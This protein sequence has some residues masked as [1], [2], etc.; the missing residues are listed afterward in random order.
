VR[1]IVHLAVPYFASWAGITVLDGGRLRSVDSAGVDEFAEGQRPRKVA[2][3]EPAAASAFRRAS[4]TAQR[5]LG[6]VGPDVVAAFAVPPGP[7]EGLATAGASLLT[8]P[9]PMAGAAAV[10]ALATIDEPDADEL[11]GFA[12]RAARALAAASAYEERGVLARTLRASL[13]PAPLPE[14]AGLE[15]AGAYRPAQESTEIGGDFYDVTPRPDGT[16]AISIGDV[17]GKGVE[18]AVLTGQVRQSLRTASLVTDDPAAA[19]H[20]LNDTLLR[21]D[22]STFATTAFGILDVRSDGARLRLASG[23]HPPPLLLR[24]DGRVEVVGVRGT[25]VGILP[26]VFFESVEVDLRPGDLL[27]LYTDGA[28]EARGPAGVLGVEPIAAALA[29][30]AGLAARAVTERLLQVVME[31][32]QGWSHD[33]IALLAIRCADGNAS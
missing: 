3:L 21:A 5:W 15:L 2:D 29:D 20:L 19:L 1:C 16:W 8:L 23:G 17:C 7:A 9:L 28:V 12:E 13:L 4:S 25:L 26:E 24:G 18:A 10:L 27:L 22:G 31:H 30:S 32:L 11:R 14:L 33:D 6:P